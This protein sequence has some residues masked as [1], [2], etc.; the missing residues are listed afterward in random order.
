MPQCAL[1]F[2]FVS[3][4]S[5][6]EITDRWAREGGDEAL[7]KGLNIEGSSTPAIFSEMIPSPDISDCMKIAT[8]NVN[9]IKS[10]LSNLLA[11]LEREKPDIA[12]LQE[13]KAPDAAFPSLA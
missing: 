6:Y 4:S 5:P 7:A 2:V 9:G 3:V 13:L 11:W 8:Y 1:S 10:R 12:C